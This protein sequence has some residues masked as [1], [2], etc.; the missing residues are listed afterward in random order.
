MFDEIVKNP[1]GGTVFLG[2]DGTGIVSQ[3]IEIAEKISSKTSAGLSFDDNPDCHFIDLLDGKREITLEQIQEVSKCQSMVSLYSDVNIFVIAHADRMNIMVQNSLLKVLEDGADNNCFLMCCENRLIP[4][5]MNRCNIVNASVPLDDEKII[6]LSQ[7]K[8]I[9]KYALRMAC[10]ERYEWIDDKD[11]LKVADM[12]DK[13][14]FIKKRCEILLILEALPEK[15]ENSLV[16]KLSE[17]MQIALFRGLFHIYSNLL[18]LRHIN[19]D[20]C[21]IEG[22]LER[23]GNLYSD[24]T[25]EMLIDTC[26]ML[27]AAETKI[28]NRSFT[29]NDYFNLIRKL[30]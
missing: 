26:S 15:S 2:K 17:N 4:T 21:K 16:K 29:H 12:F 25:N 24:W 22:Y 11:Y 9:G 8:G 5:I 30:V 7:E 23:I 20:S 19:S 18:I 14:S 27:C 28:R 6:N 3:A 13:L 10:D 1:Y